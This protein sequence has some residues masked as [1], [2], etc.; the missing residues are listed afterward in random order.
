MILKYRHHPAASRGII[1]TM[2]R[3][4]EGNNIWQRCCHDV[5]PT[6]AA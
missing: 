2:R 1:Q 6:N 3:E 4:K 5:K